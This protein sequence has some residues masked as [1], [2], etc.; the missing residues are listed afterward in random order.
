[1]TPADVG[2][3]IALLCAEEPG[4][5]AGQFHPYGWWSIDNV[6]RFPARLKEYTV[7]RPLKTAA[8]T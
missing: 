3:I 4:F 8:R 6:R 5:V 7:F 2:A 1:M